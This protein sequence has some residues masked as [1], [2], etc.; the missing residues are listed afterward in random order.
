MEK[1]QKQEKVEKKGRPDKKEEEHIKLVR[2]LQKDIDG[3][4]KI[5]H[6]LTSIKGISWN[7]SNAIC[8]K[9]KINQEK[10]IGDLTPEEIAKIS[11]FVKNPILQKFL[12]NRQKD[13]YSG[14]DEHRT[15]NDLD[16]QKEFDIKRLKKIKSYKGARHTLGQPVR[17]QRTKAHFRKNK[18]AGAGMKKKEAKK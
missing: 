13:F 18:K 14:N 4:K 5:M 1:E 12:F 16:L 17:G 6:G 9:L 11:E 15:G 3:R 10:T 2:I 8:H 7:F